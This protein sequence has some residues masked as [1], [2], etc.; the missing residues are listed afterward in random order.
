[1][2][3]RVVALA[4][5]GIILLLAISWFVFQ[6]A[7][8]EP[9]PPPA[10]PPPPPPVVQAAPPP[11]PPAPPQDAEAIVESVDGAVEKGAKGAWEKV[12]VGDRLRADDS[13]RT[14]SGA[15]ADLRIGEKSRITVAQ[16]SQ[17]VIRELTE[18]VHRFKLT[19]GHVSVDYKA[20][21]ER[22]LKI[23]G[24]GDDAV[25]ETRDAKF[26]VLSTGRAIA[27]A[28]ETGAVALQSQGATVNVA[29]GQEAI[30]AAGA[31]PSAPKEIPTSLWLKV[32]NEL[33]SA[34]AGVCGE[35]KGSAPAGSEVTIDGKPVEV[36]KDGNF[37]VRVPR[38]RGHESALVEIR[39]ASGRTKTSRV[40]CGEQLGDADDVALKWGRKKK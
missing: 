25:A 1:V 23:E 14:S 34:P 9:P 3:R 7:I 12:A 40:P 6:R 30:A 20:D 28:T 36:D 15:K 4:V 37:D 13:V 22:V 27:I 17:L 21:G 29:A 35:V 24:E 39:D 31:A 5:A 10:P 33:A 26:S 19:R 18:K 32:A 11:P 16:G 8:Y 38:L 2:N